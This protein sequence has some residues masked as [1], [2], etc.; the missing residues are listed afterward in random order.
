MG[1]KTL[2]HH[3]LERGAFDC[4]TV[5]KI[6][7]QLCSGVKQAHLRNII[8]RD[9]SLENVLWDG[10]KIAIIDL[11]YAYRSDGPPLDHIGTPGFSL[12]RQMDIRYKPLKPIP[13]HDIYSIGAILYTLLAPTSY[14]E[15]LNIIKKSY[16]EDNLQ[17]AWERSAL[18]NEV[19]SGLVEILERCLSSDH[20]RR[21][22]KID[23]LERDLQILLRS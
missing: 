18:P 2:R 17:K 14:L 23:S 21:Y 13:S 11:E 19:P 12:M 5:L 6:G 1:E 4:S 7:L 9:L 22:R 20:R 3:L 8:L 10:E 15:F 16:N